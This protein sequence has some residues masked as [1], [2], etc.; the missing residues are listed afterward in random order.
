M[1]Q[2]SN[3]H[4]D[5]ASSMCPIFAFFYIVFLCFAYNNNHHVFYKVNDLICLS[6]HQQLPTVYCRDKR[7]LRHVG[8][9]GQKKLVNSIGSKISF[10]F[11]RKCRACTC[12]CTF[13]NWT[14]VVGPSPISPFGRDKGVRGHWTQRLKSR[15]RRSRA[16]AR[17]LGCD[18]LARQLSQPGCQPQI[19]V[20]LWSTRRVERHRAAHRPGCQALK[21]IAKT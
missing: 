2:S 5:L 3:K 17:P 1:E 13:D 11:V 6:T 15:Q 19:R 14:L 18:H 21:V 16:R 20:R 10:Y 4:I 7:M 9:G 12:A 8:L